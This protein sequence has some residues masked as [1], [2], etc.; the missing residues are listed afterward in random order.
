KERIAHDIMGWYL[1]HYHERET[2]LLALYPFRLSFYRRMGFGYGTPMH[3]FLLRP[4]SF[5]R[6]ERSHG[7]RFLHETD[8]EETIACYE[9]VMERTHGMFRKTPRERRQLTTAEE[10]SVIGVQEGERLRG[11]LS[12]S[13]KERGSRHFL[14]HDLVIREWIHESTDALRRLAGFLSVQADQVDRIV[15][16]TQDDLLQ[17]IL[18]DPVNDSGRM[19]LINHEISTRGLGILYRVIDVPRIFHQ[20]RD[21]DFGGCSLKLKITLD[22]AFFPRNQGSTTLRFEEGKPVALDREGDADVEIALD[23]GDFSSL[24]LGVIPFR[25][26]HGYGLARISDPAQVG[27]IERLFAATE[28]PVCTTA[29]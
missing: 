8:R 14:R 5:P 24:L 19:F 4:E 25:K 6:G 22:D 20:L 10:R 11:Y 9:R 1:C 7:A 16:H 21:H 26:L 23:V 27:L 2:A 12:F 18:S 13:F 15:L 17:H 28:K 3:R 29:F